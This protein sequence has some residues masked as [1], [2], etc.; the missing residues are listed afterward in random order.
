MKQID[1]E[2]KAFY[3]RIVKEYQLTTAGR[4]LLAVACA[5]LSRWRQAKAILDAEGV[6]LPGS[7]SRIHPAAKVEND[8]RLSFCRM[9]KELGLDSDC[10]VSNEQKK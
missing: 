4:E 3:D 1:K 2:S 9:M 6:V 5:T 7:I 10:E 8:A